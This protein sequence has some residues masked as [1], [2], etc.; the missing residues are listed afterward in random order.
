MGA[1]FIVLFIGFIYM[2]RGQEPKR[3]LSM[4][5]LSLLTTWSIYVPAMLVGSYLLSNNLMNGVHLSASTGLASFLDDIFDPIVS[6]I[7]SWAP[8]L[9][10]FAVGVGVILLAFNL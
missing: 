5:L 4:G 6:C 7:T 1:S 9:L 2:L 8:G 10:I 3:S